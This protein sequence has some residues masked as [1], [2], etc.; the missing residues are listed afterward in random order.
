MKPNPIVLLSRY[1]V[2]GDRAYLAE[3]DMVTILDVTDPLSPTLLGNYANLEKPHRG[4]IALC[5]EGSL[6]YLVDKA[7]LLIVDTSNPSSPVLRSTIAIAQFDGFPT[8]A[9]IQVAN[10][11]VYISSD[12]RGR[13]FVAD[14]TN[15]DNPRMLGHYGEEDEWYYLSTIDVSNDT[16]YLT[17]G[18]VTDP[19]FGDDKSGLHI[20]DASE[21]ATPQLVSHYDDLVVYVSDFQV[22]GQYAYVADL[23]NGLQILDMSNPARPRVVGSLDTLEEVT[24]LH[25]VNGRAY[26]GGSDEHGDEL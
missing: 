10:N 2:A 7:D 13:M 20:I 19:Y 9:D 16:V 26:V 25:V 14:V 3:F 11:R 15:P 6:L 23:L 18:R 17:L 4:Y 1:Y 5:A 12:I 22:A 21:P 8:Y 24:A